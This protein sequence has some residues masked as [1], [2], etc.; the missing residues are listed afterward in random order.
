MRFALGIL[1]FASTFAAAQATD[2]AAIAQYDK[3]DR[4]QFLLQ[5]AKKEGSEVSIY[6][7]LI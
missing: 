7:S 1:F 6:T 2:P 3:P 4:E 5:G